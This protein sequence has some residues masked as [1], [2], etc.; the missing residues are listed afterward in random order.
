MGNRIVHFEIPVNDVERMSKFYS[1]LFGWK[2]NKQPMSGMVYWMIE[3][4]G[5]EMSDLGGGMYVKQ[6]ETD[7]PR[8]F[9]HVED[10]D[11][12]TERF[13]QAGG[14][15]VAKKQEIPG[16]GY[17]VLGV[18]PEGNMLGLFQPVQ[19]AVPSRSNKKTTARKPSGKRSSSSSAAAKKKGRM[20]KGRK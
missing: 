18:D 11:G 16:F 8:F 12:H 2:I 20:S 19:Q 4:T 5:R 10:I 1:D 7:R 14:N 9:I 3:T 13:R 15:V 17:S 6:G